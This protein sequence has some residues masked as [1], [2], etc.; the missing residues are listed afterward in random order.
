MQVN[1]SAVGWMIARRVTARHDLQWNVRSPRRGSGCHTGHRRDPHNLAAATTAVLR[2]DQVCAGRVGHRV[3]GQ[4]GSAQ[5]QGRAGH[6]RAT[7]GSY[8]LPRTPRAGL[9]TAR[10]QIRP[11][12]IGDR[13]VDHLMHTELG[14]V[15]PS[16]G[17]G[18]TS[19]R[20][21]QLLRCTKGRFV[22]DVCRTA[23]GLLC[24]SC[25]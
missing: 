12:D 6:D 23:V 2:P 1:L 21:V 15:T 20:F 17:G 3:V 10:R 25:A 18:W 13:S 5:R 14:R 22:P 8:R 16:G 7:A 11:T 4:T 24:S 19:R 9:E